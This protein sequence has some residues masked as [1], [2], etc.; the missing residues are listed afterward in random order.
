MFI[1]ESCVKNNYKNDFFAPIPSRGKCESCGQ[2]KDCMDIPSKYLIA[3]EIEFEEL[4]QKITA[5][6]NITEDQKKSIICAIIG[7][8]KICTTCFGYR[9]CG[10]CGAQVGDSLG[11][12]D[13]G[14]KEAVIIGHNCDSCK[15]NY[16]NCDWKDKLYCKDPFAVKSDWDEE[17]KNLP[18]LLEI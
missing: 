13:Y 16:E 1:C 18:Y 9:Y 15:A 2:I 5:L 14:V 4:K 12:I 8:S 7:H 3:K 10:R 17:Y 11:S 6:G